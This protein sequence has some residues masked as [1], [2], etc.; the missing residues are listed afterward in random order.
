M[1][2]TAG[3]SGQYFLNREENGEMVAS[4]EEKGGPGHTRE[5]FCPTKTLDYGPIL[6]VGFWRDVTP[7]LGCLAGILLGFFTGLLPQLS[8]S[9][10]GVDGKHLKR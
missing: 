6:Q 10:T 7:G 2:E 5:S 4:R 3:R 9:R 1:P 8:A